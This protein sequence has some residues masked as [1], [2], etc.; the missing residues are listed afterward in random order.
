MEDWS[1]RGAR[2]RSVRVSS[3]GVVELSPAWS[4]SPSSSSSSSSS[5]EGWDICDKRR[6]MQLMEMERRCGFFCR[7]RWMAAPRFKMGFM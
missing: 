1:E 7:E 5:W 3:E 4:P 6:A 2:Y